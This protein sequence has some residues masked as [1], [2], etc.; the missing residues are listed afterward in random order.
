M[1]GW[2]REKDE[3]FAIAFGQK[4]LTVSETPSKNSRPCFEDVFWRTPTF[5]DKRLHPL[6]FVGEKID[7]LL[8]RIKKT[9][10]DRW[11]VPVG[12]MTPRLPEIDPPSSRE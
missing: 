4:I 7:Y 8:V 1:F 6:G 9:V 11:G 3:G 5:Y 2:E 12:V 10:R